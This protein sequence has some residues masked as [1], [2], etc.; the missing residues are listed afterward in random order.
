MPDLE[1]E[2]GH[3]ILTPRD[4]ALVLKV[5]ISTPQ[6]PD[7]LPES[8]RN[9]GLHLKPLTSDFLSLTIPFVPFSYIVQ[10]PK[11]LEI[12]PVEALL[13]LFGVFKIEGGARTNMVYVPLAV[14]FKC[15]PF[16]KF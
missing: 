5:P 14:V 1:R 9:L 8:A 3:H 10:G 12:C 7:L 2:R 15:H 13:L 4:E 6:K 11:R 16:C